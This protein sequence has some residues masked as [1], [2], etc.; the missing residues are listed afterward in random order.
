MDE[1]ALVTGR[2]IESRF[3]IDR[4]SVQMLAL[5]Y[6]RLTTQTTLDDVEN[7]TNGTSSS[8]EIPVL[9]SSEVTP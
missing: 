2:T 4:F 5:A 6:Q 9:L 7:D 8:V 3:R 1:V